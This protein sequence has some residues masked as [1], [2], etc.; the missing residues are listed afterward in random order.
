MILRIISFINYELNFIQQ[1][2]YKFKIQN[3]PKL[4]IIS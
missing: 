4:E 1:K 3:K 2:K